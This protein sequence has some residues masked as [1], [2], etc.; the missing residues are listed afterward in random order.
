MTPELFIKQGDTAA[1]LTA[2]KQ[3]VQ[4]APADAKCRIALF[5]IESVFG[6]WEKARTQLE[7]LAGMDF[8]SST[9]A[10]V[11]APVLECEAVRA[12]VFAGKKTPII[13]GEPEEWM[14]LLVQA[15]QHIAAG[16]V[17]AAETL[18]THALEAAPAIG[19]TIN[20]KP[21]EWVADA[22]SRLGPILEVIMDGCYR[23]V[24]FS[25]ITSIDIEPPNDLRDLVWA[26]AKFEWTN[27]GIASGLIPTR[28]PGS[29]SSADP[30]V[31]LGRKTEWTEQPG[32]TY[33][34]LGQ[35]LFAT[36]QEDFALLEVRSVKL[37]AAEPASPETVS[38]AN[39]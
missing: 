11:F 17:A 15:N 6:H 39:E 2:A 13:F 16:E 5:Q 21:F 32:N 4:K 36:D 38:A 8:D 14:G 23:W 10:L 20:G 1:A 27:G 7:V 29:E 35:R 3:A 18:R 33:L 12:D 31:Q 25:R 37:N 26:N 34:G 24:P 9:L 22:D 28:Y 30:L 19:G